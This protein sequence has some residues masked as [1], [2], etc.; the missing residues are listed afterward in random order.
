MDGRDLRVRRRASWRVGRSDAEGREKYMCWVEFWV[1]MF[2]VG[3]GAGKGV[4]SGH[5][6]ARRGYLCNALVCL[7]T[8]IRD[9]RKMRLRVCCLVYE[10]TL[11][12]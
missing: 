3:I 5:E 2:D 11:G 1:A 9:C 6:Q 8:K 12:E 7:L 4:Q 10:V